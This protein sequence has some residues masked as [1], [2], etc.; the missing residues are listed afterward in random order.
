VLF[1]DEPTTGLDPGARAALWSELRA[2]QRSGDT[3]L[4]LTTHSMEEADALCDGI[5]ILD[6]GRVVAR[7]A[8][9][10]LKAELG[11][12]VVTLVL[13][14]PDA[15]E[16][17]LAALPGVASVTRDAERSSLRITVTEGPRRLP[18]LLEC[19]RDGGVVEVDL[20][21]P[22]LEHVFLHHTGHAFEGVAE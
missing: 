14:R 13:E 11:G 10:A 8:P 16:A 7:G 9:E 20:R 1:L 22:S 4:F 3:T 21:R 5:A 17:A 12:D 2:L 15:V 18:A 19:A 6:G